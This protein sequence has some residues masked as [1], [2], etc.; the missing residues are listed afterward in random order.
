PESPV[1][2]FDRVHE[3]LMHLIIV[4]RD[5]GYFE[6]VHPDLDPATGVFRMRYTFPAG[7]EYRL[8]AD[9][10]PK[11]AGM[12]VL[13][14]SLAVEGNPAANR[15]TLAPTEPRRRSAGGVEIDI[16][17]KTGPLKARTDQTLGVTYTA[18]GAPV[19][20]LQP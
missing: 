17:P 6:H 4:S 12:Q 5:L 10:T 20:D 14:A 19:T 2:Q 15:T 9:V 8:F 1:R 3:Q 11:D 7:G 16:K 13:V 18:N